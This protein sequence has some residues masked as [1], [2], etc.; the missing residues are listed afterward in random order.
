MTTEPEVEPQTKPRLEPDALTELERRLSGTRIRL[1]AKAPFFAA[2]ALFARMEMRD[3]IPTAATDGRDIFWNPRFLQSLSFAETSGVLLHEVLHAALLH[4]TRRGTRD[5]LIWN[6]AADIVVNGIIAAEIEKKG[7]E[8]QAYLALP[9]GAL[10]APDL[11]KFSVEEV[12]ELLQKD[13]RVLS[14]TWC[15]LLNGSGIDTEAEY[16]RIEAHWRAAQAQA[17]AMLQGAGQGSLPAELMR[18]MSLAGSS[19]LDWRSHLWRFLVRTPTDFTGFDR[20]FIGRGLYLEALEGESLRVFVAVDTSG[21]IGDTQLAQFLQEVQGIL[22]TYPHISC[23]LFYVD[24]AAYGP[25]PL[26]AETDV[27]AFPRP[28]GGGGTDFRPFFTAVEKEQREGDGSTAYSQLA[29]SET[30]CV[31]L[32]DGYGT[33]PE[34][35]PEEAVLWV[36]LPGGLQLDAFPFGETVRLI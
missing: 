17:S 15:D 22:S 36:V 18:E 8:E 10:R 27:T 35:V 26:T 31:Y 2:L 29:Q 28:V 11:E 24:A 3:T 25:Y 5:P 6:I 12:Y 16:A 7:K 21:S 1:R 9:T 34:A 23:S 4:V 30:L 13:G 14:L 19:K 33:F 20:R 32:T